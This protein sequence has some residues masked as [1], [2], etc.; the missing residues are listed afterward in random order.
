LTYA[1]YHLWAAGADYD[2]LH[3][4]LKT[5]TQTPFE[6]FRHVS[7]RFEI[8]SF[9]SKRSTTVQRELIESFGYLPFEGPIVMNNADLRIV[10][11]EEFEHKVTA[12]K[13][14]F[15]GRLVGTSGRL[16][17]NKY[18]LKKRSYISRTSMD[19]ELSLVT[20]NMT[21]AAPGKIMYDPFV[22]TGSFSIACAHFGAAAF[23]SDIDPRSI[24]GVSA[25]KSLLGNFEQYDIV[26]NFL[27]SFAADLTHTP[28]RQAQL[29]DGIV[30]D[31]PYGIREGPKV[32][33]YRDTG[34]RK[35]VMVNGKPAHL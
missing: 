15:I 9:K 6:S 24:R 29:F 20:A 2:Q 13:R 17:M 34:D 7:F 12:P 19:A 10:V 35:V 26:H 3:H 27:D 16:A 8:D 31:P 25:G 23:G 22:G 28:L 18:D 33:G 14:L 4:Q 32:L 5:N 1:I 21:L 11:F 30:C